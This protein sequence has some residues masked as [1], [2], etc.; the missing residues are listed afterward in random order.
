MSHLPD[1]NKV[2]EELSE[3]SA[4]LTW[5]KLRADRRK[6]RVYVRM[7]RAG[8]EKGVVPE[9]FR[10][11]LIRAKLKA[12][13]A[14]EIIAILKEP[15]VAKAL[16][17]DVNSIS[18]RAA[19][20]MARGD[21]SPEP[22]ISP[23]RDTGNQAARHLQE[24]IEE[25]C[26]T[27][28]SGNNATNPARLDA[29][30]FSLEVSIMDGEP[31]GRLSSPAGNGAVTENRA[32]WRRASLRLSPHNAQQLS[33]IG[34]LSGLSRSEVLEV[35]LRRKAHPSLLRRLPNKFRLGTCPKNRGKQTSAQ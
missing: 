19:L 29:G 6:E 26:R 34:A 9:V 33:L 24:H 32:N 14:S 16:T 1:S 23:R 31:A 28:F 7:V 35:L 20:K 17:R 27:L 4:Q 30:I 13:R 22:S 5:T 8:L 3:T 12:T 2:Q 11:R 21:Y 10:R 15:H 25:L 18:F